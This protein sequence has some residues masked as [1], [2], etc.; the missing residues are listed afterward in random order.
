MKEQQQSSDVHHWTPTPPC[1]G[2]NSGTVS[3][4][5]TATVPMAPSSRRRL[6]LCVALLQSGPAFFTSQRG[7]G[8]RAQPQVPRLSPNRLVQVLA[9]A[10]GMLIPSSIDLPL[11]EE[12]RHEEVL[13]P[14][15]IPASSLRGDL[16]AASGAHAARDRLEHAAPGLPS[17]AI[18]S[19]YPIGRATPGLQSLTTNPAA[20]AWSSNLGRKHLEQREQAP[21]PLGV[22]RHGGALC[23]PSPPP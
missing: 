14:D 3:M 13:R 5:A 22:A 8:S 9:V 2:G 16:Q 15:V 17:R 20:P 1:H 10:V 23:W 12:V 4:P 18:T 6:V 11:S 7:M 19:A 21:P